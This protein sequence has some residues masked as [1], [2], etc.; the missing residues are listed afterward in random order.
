MSWTWSYVKFVYD[1]KNYVKNMSQIWLSHNI[2]CNCIYIRVTACSMTKTTYLNHNV[3]FFCFLF[4]SA[5]KNSQVSCFIFSQLKCTSHRPISVA[6]FVWRINRVS[7]LVLSLQHNVFS[8]N[9]EFLVGVWE[10]A[11]QPHFK[12]APGHYGFLG[13]SALFRNI[14]IQNL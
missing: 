13:W 11:L 14:L 9:M 7:G 4:L 3:Q 12:C 2:V 5:S 6:L 10:A 8:L 1:F